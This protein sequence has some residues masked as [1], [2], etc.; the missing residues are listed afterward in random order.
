MRYPFCLCS[1][2]AILLLPVH[3]AQSQWVP[4][5]GPY[6]GSVYS[7]AAL[8]STLFVGAER[9][10][11]RSTD[12]GMTWQ[13]SENVRKPYSVRSIVICGGR[14]FAAASS[15]RGMFSS[16]DIYMS[17]D[18]GRTW[19]VE[20]SGLDP[21]EDIISTTLAV[22]GDTV[23]AGT[24]TGV[25]C[26]TS[27][28]K[29]WRSA[30]GNVPNNAV[31]V[32]CSSSDAVYAIMGRGL[33]RTRNSG[34]SWTL[35]DSNSTWHL[36][37]STLLVQDSVIIAGIGIGYNSNVSTNLG[38]TWTAGHIGSTHSSVNALVLGAGALYAGTSEGVFRSLD[39]GTTWTAVS[40]G[41]PKTSINALCVGG[42]I[43]A[44]GSYGSVYI[45]ADSAKHW[46]ASNS[47]FSCSVIRALAIDA[48][49]LYAGTQ[50]GVSISSDG[51]EHWRDVSLNGREVF[52]DALVAKNGMV[53][54]GSSHNGLFRSTDGGSTWSKVNEDSL[55]WAESEIFVT[56]DSI[57]TMQGDR[58]VYLSIDSGRNWMQ[59]S[60]QQFSVLAFCAVHGYMF[61]AGYDGIFRSSDGGNRWDCMSAL[62]A[63]D[64]AN[65]G[66]MVFALTETGGVL[67]SINDG[68]TW[69]RSSTWPTHPG[70]WFATAIAV[71]GK[72]VFVS[73]YDGFGIGTVWSSNDLGA[74]WTSIDDGT[75]GTD[76]AA[77]ATTPLMLF[78]G[79]WF[80]TV[81]RRPLSELVPVENRMA[82]VP[83][84]IQLE[85]NAPNPF[86]QQTQISYTLQFGGYATLKVYDISGRTIATLV[87]EDVVAGTHH[88]MWD[89][90]GLPS[91]VYVCRL[92]AGQYM[93]ARTMVFAH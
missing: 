85:Q 75:D 80:S 79:G 36:N 92:T 84:G 7:M 55:Y 29:S 93:A 24:E 51:G 61:A 8:G 10:I 45:S 87:D 9:D 12:G 59:R 27:G 88:M 35:I 16:E 17:V 78:A 19:S 33:Y 72:T 53:Y 83:A 31:W 60:V 69:T 13:P 6:G 57:F 76:I 28:E 52:V 5:N 74:T 49:V 54:A 46:T 71:H 48:G 23:F 2:L 18:T 34:M 39:H 81:L 91:G 21:S 22:K 40:A 3:Q 56:G 58:H 64:L 77:F 70:I 38:V 90:G 14:I 89:A 1:I 26:R 73:A 32:L 50:S 68:V 30:Q 43:I 41:I 20:N 82:V 44:A 67:L 65:D 47:G 86:S 66:E 63:I 62:A 11:Y 42:G 15:D 4:T 37:P 25:F